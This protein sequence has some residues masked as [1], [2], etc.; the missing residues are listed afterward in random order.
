MIVDTIRGLHLQAS[1]VHTIVRA[2]RSLVDQLIPS[3]HLLIVYL[4]LNRRSRRS[5]IG[6]SVGRSLDLKW[7]T[8]LHLVKL[9]ELCRGLDDLKRTRHPCRIILVAG[10]QG[11]E[12]KESNEGSLHRI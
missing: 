2:T 12:G 9:L 8:E 11:S 4:P 7:R 6:E 5:S 10:A 3:S 1:D